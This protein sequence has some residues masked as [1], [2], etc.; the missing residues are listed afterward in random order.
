MSECQSYLPTEEIARRYA[1]DLCGLQLDG[2]FRLA[3]YSFDGVLGYK[4]ACQLVD[5][6]RQVN[7]VAVFDTRLSG[8]S[9][10]NLAG[11]L[12]IALAIVSNLTGWVLENI[13]RAEPEGLIA[14]LNIHLQILA[15]RGSHILSSGSSMPK[16]P[17][18]D[19]LFDVNPL[20]RKNVKMMESNLRSLCQYAP[21]H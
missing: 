9:R 8:F 5:R 18:I 6:C 1:D 10:A 15:K 2:S 16:K 17:E 13:L 21:K 4:T 7:L 19:D 14:G 11:C 20:P 12:G 3:G